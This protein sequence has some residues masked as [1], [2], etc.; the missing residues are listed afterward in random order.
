MQKSCHFFQIIIFFNSLPDLVRF[1]FD[2]PLEFVAL[3]LNFTK[4]I[5]LLNLDDFIQI[6]GQVFQFLK[7]TVEFLNLFTFHPK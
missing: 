6:F 1:H 3:S 5:F 2:L 4:Q 7:K